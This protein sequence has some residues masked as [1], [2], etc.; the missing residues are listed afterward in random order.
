[1]AV[2]RYVTGAFD[3]GQ[4]DPGQ[5]G[6]KPR[7]GAAL[8]VTRALGTVWAVGF[9]DW[10]TSADAAPDGR[11]ELVT[12]GCCLAADA[13]R[14]EALAQT[15]AGRWH[16]AA[17]LPGS[18]LAV[19]RDGE[20][21]HIAG[22]RA[23]TVVVHWLLDGGTVL[24][25]TSA[26]ALAAYRQCEPDLARVLA[27]FAVR[28]VD[29]LGE[30]SCFT[31]VNRV[32]PGQ[33]LVLEPGRA[34]RTEPLPSAGPLDFMA[35]TGLLEERLTV[36]VE[37]RALL[38]GRLSA[39][40]SGGIDSSTLTALAAQFTDLLA[41][42]YT[43][44][45]ME[46]EDDG[47]YARRIAADYPAITHR[48]V[49]GDTEKVRQFDGL[50]GLLPVTDSPSLSVGVLAVKGAQLAPVR[51][52]ESGA[53][54]TGRG[55]DDVLDAV[56]TAVLDLYRT[57]RRVEAGRRLAAFARER[58]CSTAA[59]LRQAH[60]T[61]RTPYG[62]ALD[63]LADTICG[64]APLDRSQL[65]AP[66]ESLSWCGTLPAAA[67]LTRD[68]R[69]QVAA[70]LTTPPGSETGP[71]QL[72]ERLFLERMGE[73]HATYDQIA[74]QLFQVPIHAPYL[75][76]QVVDVCHAVPGW[77]R[78]VPGDFKPLVRAAFTGRV[79]GYLLGRRTKTAMTRTVATGMRANAPF[80]RALFN[81]S[82][83][84]GAG[85]IDPRPARVAL[86]AALRGEPAALAC[87]H[88]LIATE[89]WLATIPTG[90]DTWWE[91]NEE[92]EEITW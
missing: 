3:T 62:H 34:P 77:Q 76:N 67:W 31:G 45:H 60:T 85:L 64:R 2:M 11:A 10:E 65:V 6:W 78:R 17:R 68:G 5:V 84:A 74:R 69:A 48:I 26:L 1:M 8:P 81:T 7:G 73:E 36:A 28:G 46:D 41:V 66:W 9:E 49:H 61:L 90:R 70:L 52:W 25:S 27:A 23:A 43:D 50:T 79:P 22:D 35:G 88:Y 89:L 44:R 51:A 24:W 37:R 32:P 39:D 16:R 75:D 59:V 13:E 29:L 38:P 53:H 72:H 56:P 19:V 42:T 91:P 18:Y 87:L 55:G 92:H 54:L 82:L 71:A 30:H 83:L 12:V 21:V 47:V 40:L 20:R 63:A 33:A 80:I 58:R 15:A 4:Q 14:S 86:E 57:G